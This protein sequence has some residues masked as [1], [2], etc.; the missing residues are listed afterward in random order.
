MGNGADP[1]AGGGAGGGIPGQDG[2]PAGLE[3]GLA[4][5]QASLAAGRVDPS[6][7]PPLECFGQL[8]RARVFA[9]AVR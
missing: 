6:A 2:D 3:E 1:A 8:K 5:G 9:P 4:A 7:A